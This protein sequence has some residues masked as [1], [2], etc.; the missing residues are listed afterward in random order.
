M[1]NSECE[2]PYLAVCHVTFTYGSSFYSTKMN[3]SFNHVWLGCYLLS[4]ISFFFLVILS[5]TPP[6]PKLASLQ[7][8]QPVIIPLPSPNSSCPCHTVSVWLQVWDREKFTFYIYIYAFSRR[9]YP[10][11]L[12]LHSSYSFYILSAL[13]FPGNRT[14]DLSVASAMILALL[15]LPVELQERNCILMSLFNA[16]A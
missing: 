6:P 14:H 11:R 5:F 7:S 1:Q 10:K 13:A 3:L 4:F 8:V 9:F 12:T 2:S 16:K 15:A